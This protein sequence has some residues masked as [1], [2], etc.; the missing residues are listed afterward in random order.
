[1]HALSADLTAV[2]SVLHVTGAGSAAVAGSK[3]GGNFTLEETSPRRIMQAL[4][5]APYRPADELALTR[6]AAQGNWS[7]TPSRLC[8]CRKSP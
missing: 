5:S 6:L 7:L 2:D 4:S 3:L 8:S 1:M